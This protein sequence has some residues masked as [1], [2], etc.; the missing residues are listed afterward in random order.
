M[1]GE[2]LTASALLASGAI[3]VIVFTQQVSTG[4]R[5]RE[6]RRLT[7]ASPPHPAI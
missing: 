1:R 7:C 3:V 5:K 4:A 2:F 6:S